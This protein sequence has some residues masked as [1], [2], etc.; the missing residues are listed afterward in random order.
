M[1]ILYF[2]DIRH[3]LGLNEEILSLPEGVVTLADLRQFLQNKGEK[4]AIAFA[5]DKVIR[6]AV[7]CE[8][9]DFSKPVSDSDEVAF[10]PPV[11]GG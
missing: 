6:C 4:Y 8:F 9:S 1:K 2:A 10:F 5:T 11:T 3:R 7:N